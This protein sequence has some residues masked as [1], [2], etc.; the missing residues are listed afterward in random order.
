MARKTK[1][2]KDLI[3]QAEKLIKL[4]NYN[5]TVT[6]YLGIHQST[7]YKWMQDGENAKSGLKKELFDRIKSAESHAEIRNVQLI[8]NA[9]NNTWQ[10][11]AW[12][13]ER[14]FPDRWGNKEKMQLSGDVGVQIVDNI[15]KDDK[16]ED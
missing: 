16:G 13:L 3:E 15:P 1:L 6:Q 2:T 7:W 10:A 14:K 5:T 4:G 9:G 12:Y 11:A 8:Q